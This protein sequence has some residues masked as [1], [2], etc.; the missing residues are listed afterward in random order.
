MKVNMANTKAVIWKSKVKQIGHMIQNLNSWQSDDDDV[1][2][3]SLKMERPKNIKA[4]KAKVHDI[5]I[6][7]IISE[8]YPPTQGKYF[9]N[10]TFI[11]SFCIISEYKNSSQ[12]W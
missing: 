12:T 11:V 2:G 1:S 6:A 9:L 8:L 5:T 4:N 10:L 3:S 7:R